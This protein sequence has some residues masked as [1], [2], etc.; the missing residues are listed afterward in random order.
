MKQDLEK[1]LTTRFIAQA[2]EATWLSPIVW[3]YENP[4]LLPFTEEVL[5]M[6]VGHEVYW[7]FLD[8]FYSYH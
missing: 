2:E 3:I 1:L 4:Y 6:V 5:D 8:G 7:S